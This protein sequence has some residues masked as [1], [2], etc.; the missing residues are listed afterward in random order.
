MN[1]LCSNFNIPQILVLCHSKELLIMLGQEA[2]VCEAAQL[3]IYF[4]IPGLI[5]VTQFETTRRYLQGMGI[6]YISM[7]IQTFTMFLHLLWGY[8][9]IFYLDFGLIGIAVATSITYF[10]DF[11]LIHIVVHFYKGL[12][13]RESWH[14]FNAD[15]FKG[16]LEFLYYGVPSALVY[17]LEWWSFEI[18]SI[19][20][21]FLSIQELAANVIILNIC[22]FFYQ[23]PEG[24]GFAISNL[25]GN[26]LGEMNA[27]KSRKYAFASIGI[28]IISCLSIII[29]IIL[30]AILHPFILK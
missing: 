15:S 2:S 12:V 9:L 16:L 1:C 26:S 8:F 19:F 28:M 24:V 30:V 29:F 5:A 21:G 6:F 10:A 11:L 13:P 22:I 3:Y 17:S 7:Y 20:A 14:F 27:Q 25:V 18:L 4:I 23:I